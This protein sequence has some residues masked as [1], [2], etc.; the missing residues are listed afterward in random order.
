M[1]TQSPSCATVHVAITDVDGRVT[2]KVVF[3][4]AF[5][6]S[7]AEALRDVGIS[8]DDFY[9]SIDG[10][11]QNEGL[12]IA[13]LRSM[14]QPIL[15]EGR[16][17]VGRTSGL[18]ALSP[19]VLLL[20]F[21]N[22]VALTMSR[23]CRHAQYL[24]E[25]ATPKLRLHL[26]V[27]SM[28]NPREVCTGLQR[29][30]ARF[31]VK[32]LFLSSVGLRRVSDADS[33][34]LEVVLKSMEH[35]DALDVSLNYRIH[36]H[37][38][39][40]KAPQALRHL[41]LSKTS[42]SMAAFR[43]LASANWSGLVSLCMIDI[44]CVDSADMGLALAP[45]L[46]RL[47]V[48]QR[49]DLSRVHLTGAG[50]RLAAAVSNM[51][52]LRNLR[53]SNTHLL[54]SGLLYVLA[55]LGMHCTQLQDLD[56]SNCFDY[57][58]R[59]ITTEE[60]EQRHADLREMQLAL[61]GMT[62]LTSLNLSRNKFLSCGN[63]IVRCMASLPALTSLEMNECNLGNHDID[64][65]GMWVLRRCPMQHLSLQDNV[66]THFHSLAPGAWHCTTLTTLDLRENRIQSEEAY[67]AKRISH[68][69]RL[70]M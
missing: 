62:S 38:A 15:L 60:H 4:P 66:V 35:L 16:P 55:S 68:R 24:I 48:L 57:G 40:L 29:M 36:R 20:I 10:R 65:M 50:P 47:V 51:S 27:K 31:A 61:R 49:L 11:M 5:R 14:P 12:R 45:I 44:D 7:L 53:L 63:A 17:K 56:A 30:A 6:K 37:W 39:V 18:M 22:D 64:A 32:T 25:H 54:E 59:L 33:Y 26:Q 46:E 13:D 70:L 58:G 1:A 23:V 2:R 41:D 34:R 21:R 52:C 8:N 43:E 42:M 28:A 9:W 3:F 69:L 19:D 67:W